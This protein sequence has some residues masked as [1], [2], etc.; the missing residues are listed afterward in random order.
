MKH[1]ILYSACRFNY[2]TRQDSYFVA[3]EYSGKLKRICGKVQGEQETG[4]MA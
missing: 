2:T 4:N 3:L 1:V